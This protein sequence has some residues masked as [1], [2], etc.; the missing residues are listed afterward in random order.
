M[1]SCEGWNPGM[2]GCCCPFFFRYPTLSCCLFCC[3]ETRFLTDQGAKELI[4][5]LEKL[6]PGSSDVLD[7][8]LML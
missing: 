4:F 6:K 1:M 8:T 7:E 2:F 5:L 3:F